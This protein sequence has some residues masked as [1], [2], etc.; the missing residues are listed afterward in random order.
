[1]GR[2]NR[3]FQFIKE[4]ITK[5]DAQLPII[6]QNITKMQDEV[7]YNKEEVL[8]LKQEGS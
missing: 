8:E 1:M 7:V 3:E 6:N 4:A 5:N 2:H